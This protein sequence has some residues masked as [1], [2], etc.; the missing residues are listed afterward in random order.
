[1][2]IEIISATHN[3][4]DGMLVTVEV[5]INKG[6][7]SFNIVGLPDTAIKE[8]KERVRSAIVNSGYE[9]P[10]G[11][12]TINL[13]PADI[14]KI[15][16]LLDL[17]IA[18]GIL[19]KSN[20]IKT[21]DLKEF[22][23]F[24][25]LSLGGQLKEIKG[26]LPIIFEGDSKK[27]NNFIFPLNNLKELRYF[28]IGN[29]Y[30]FKNLNEVISFIENKDLLPYIFDKEEYFIKKEDFNY[31]DIIGQNTSKRVMQISAAGRHNVLLYGTPGAGKTMLARALPSIMPPLS[32]K[33]EMEIAKI[34]SAS[35]LFSGDNY[36]I[37]P[38]RNPHH[39]ITRT[40]LVGGGKE[41][42]AGEITLAHNGVLF[43][44]EILEFKREVLEVLR[45]PL[46][47]KV[48]NITRI[49]GSYKLPSNFLLIAA[50]NTCQCGMYLSGYHDNKC[51]CSEGE[52]KRYMAKLSRAL[53]DRIDLLNFVPKIKYD[54]I[55]N[56][57]NNI[58]SE[59]MKENVLKARE[60]QNYRFKNTIYNY[61]SEVKGKDMDN[62]FNIS[63][64]SKLLIESFYKNFDLTMR[65][66]DKLLKV[67]RTIADL[68]GCHN[69]C[70]YHII[71]ALGYRKNIEGEI[72]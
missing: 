17:P 8:S 27:K 70:D 11:R 31:S 44:D 47:E 20:Q 21:K 24:G 58:S 2:S 19:M 25:E 50:C 7:P 33:E 55:N 35:G 34:Y 36:V 45:E 56:R 32:N 53:L 63:N 1:M 22:I 60:V 59:K 68:D 69:I 71:E 43:L 29:F 42:K 23:I 30:P 37:R 12:I 13:A 26:I 5:D 46:E 41:I 16:S 14:R 18:I 62:L 66:Y 10:L 40:A 39:T 3:G 38:F 28:N 9:F 64:S 49:N 67:S 72:V 57:N 54:E 15:G 4:L 48:I 65:G 51:I 61:N 6:M 52:R